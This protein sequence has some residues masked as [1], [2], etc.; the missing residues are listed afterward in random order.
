VFCKELLALRATA[1]SRNRIVSFVLLVLVQLMVR[2]CVAA[3]FL[4]TR[5]A[6]DIYLRSKLVQ[7]RIVT[8]F[9]P[10]VDGAD[11]RIFGTLSV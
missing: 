10:A 6:Q 4:L 8:S 5:A 9:L 7:L 1:A 3:F 2:V 11:T